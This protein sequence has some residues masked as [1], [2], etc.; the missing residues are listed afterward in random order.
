MVRSMFKRKIYDRLLE[1]K[2]RPHKPLVVKG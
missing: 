2:N 1:W